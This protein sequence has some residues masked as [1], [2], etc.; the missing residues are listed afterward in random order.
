MFCKH[1]GKELAEGSKFC[2]YCGGNLEENNENSKMTNQ[3]S[4]DSGSAGWGILGFLIP[5]VGL[6]LFIVWHDSKPNNARN[7]GIG[8]LICVC[9]SI[10]I[11]IFSVCAVAASGAQF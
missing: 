9:L 10:V 4:Y 8:A 7:A 2:P 5:V 3:T 1:C 6:I 11:S